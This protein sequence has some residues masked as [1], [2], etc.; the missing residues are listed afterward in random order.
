[1]THLEISTIL[2]LPYTETAMLLS[3]FINTRPLKLCANPTLISTV[4]LCIMAPM[5]SEQILKV[6]VEPEHV[7]CS[8]MSPPY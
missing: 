7:A 6:A 8:G 4:D 1:M 5:S 2:G 3:L